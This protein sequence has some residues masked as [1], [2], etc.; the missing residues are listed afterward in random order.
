M[1]DPI[2]FTLDGRE[3]EARPG[4]TIW[5]VAQREG[6]DDPASVLAARARLPR[7]RQLPR[8][9]GRGRGRAGAGRLLHPAARGR[10]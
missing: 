5:Q 9:H 3:V 2:R 10:A 1:T 8:L 7:R 6:I 4:E